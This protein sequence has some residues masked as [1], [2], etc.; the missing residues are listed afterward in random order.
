MAYEGNVE[1]I[2]GLIPANGQNFPLVHMDHVYVG[3]DWRL[4]DVLRDIKYEDIEGT[5]ELSPNVAEIGRTIDSITVSWNLNRI[6]DR[7]VINGSHEVE[8]PTGVGSD[9]VTNLGLTES[10]SITFSVFDDG[11]PVKPASAKIL[12]IDFLFSHPIFWGCKTIPISGEIDS[13]F[14]RTLTSELRNTFKG[15]YNVTAQEGQHIWFA[16]PDS[17]GFPQFSV[18][19]WH[20]GFIHVAAIDYTNEYNHTETYRVYRSGQ[21]SLGSLSVVIA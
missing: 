13:A 16:F 1:L 20:G 9:T 5:V 18:N 14:L 12:S 8:S 11:N 10:T 21:P 3:D 4:S 7:I 2:N 6:P 15:T 17:F 19:G